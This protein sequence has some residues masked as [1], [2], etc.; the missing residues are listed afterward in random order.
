MPQEQLLVPLTATDIKV[1]ILRN[2]D[3]L[4]GLARA[5]RDEDPSLQV[6]EQVLSRVIHRRAPYV[7]QEVRE[8]LAKYLGVDVSQ[9]GRE[10][11]EK[12]VVEEGAELAEATA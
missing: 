10:P 5:W 2:G 8:R 7:Y 1:V 12:H 11:S 4:A 6:D 3:T 9:V